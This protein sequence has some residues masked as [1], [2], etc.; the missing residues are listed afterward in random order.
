MGL[1]L[2]GMVECSFGVVV[3]VVVVEMVEVKCGGDGRG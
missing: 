3:V 2:D 1:F